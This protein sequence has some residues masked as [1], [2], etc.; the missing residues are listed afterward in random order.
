MKVTRVNGALQVTL[1]KRNLQTLLNKLDRAESKRTIYKFTNEGL[2]FVTAEDD[3]THYSD[4]TPGAMHP[5]DAPSIA[6]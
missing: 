1:S 2:V 3:A 6:A 4:R 5:E